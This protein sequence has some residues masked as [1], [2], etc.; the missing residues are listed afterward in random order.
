MTILPTDFRPGLGKSGQPID[1]LANYYSLNMF[2]EN[3]KPVTEMVFNRYH[4]TLKLGTLENMSVDE[5]RGNP[6]PYVLLVCL[7]PTT[8]NFT[9]YAT[10]VNFTSEHHFR[11]VRKNREFCQSQDF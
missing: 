7:L 3:Y 9:S 5:R 4:V 6:R 2:D 10:T 8:V 1:L 11:K